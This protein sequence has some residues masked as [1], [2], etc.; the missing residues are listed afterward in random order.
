MDEI[1]SEWLGGE[2]AFNGFARWQLWYGNPNKAAVLF[3]EVALAGV[4]LL[5]CRRRGLRVLGVLTF[6]ASACS[7]L[8]TFSRG[9][10]VSLLAGCVSMAPCLFRRREGRRLRLLCCAAACLVLVLVSLRIGFA[11]RLAHGIGGVDR[12]VA[13][14]TTL[15]SAVPQMVRDAPLG[16]GTGK[17]GE[18]YMQWYQPLDRQERYRTLVSSHLTVVVEFGV[19]GGLVW[20]LLWA[21]LLR[22]GFCFGRED[23]F[24]LCLAEWSAL[25]VAGAFSSVCEDWT[26]WVVPALVLVAVSARYPQ[27]L[28]VSLADCSCFRY[29]SLVC[30]TYAVGMMAVAAVSPETGVRRRGGR[31]LV[32]TGTRAVWLVPDDA[33][34]GGRMYPREVRSFLRNGGD[35]TFGI[36]E[37]AEAVPTDADYVVVCG[38]ARA[39]GVRGRKKTVWLS[40][41]RPVEAMKAGDA[42][43]VGAFAEARDLFGADALVVDGAAAYIPDWPEI[44]TGLCFRGGDLEADKGNS[45]FR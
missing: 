39:A 43:V 40:P 44:V 41:D 22:S 27:T 36:A 29:L 20:V 32:G 13:N 6:A 42:V 3:A 11:E 31:T 2:F 23:G 1:L 30:F 21:F 16:W 38:T 24:W 34:L 45:H 28:K 8:F 35:F 19:V 17:S 37:G 7:L 14:R 9:G 15:W 12:S 18:A 26:L 10:L 33:V 25:C 5:A 4:A